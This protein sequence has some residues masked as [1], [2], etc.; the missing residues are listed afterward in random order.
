MDIKNKI[1]AKVDHDLRN[2]G[3]VADIA[4][5]QT[6]YALI[7]N[8]FTT[9]PEQ[10]VEVA[11][12][13]SKYRVFGLG[14]NQKREIRYT[15]PSFVLTKDYAADKYK[16]FIPEA[17]G[18][19]A[20]GEV[21]ST[22]ILGTPMDICTQTFRQFGKFETLSEANNFLS[23]LKT[24]FFRAL[25][26]IVKNTQHAPAKVYM[27]VPLQDFSKSWNDTELYSK[28]N[29]TQEEIDFIETNI[30]VME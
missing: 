8:V 25:V 4:S 29:L 27:Y 14:K 3:S 30:Q 23:Y 1:K 10:F 21:P 18:C 9:L 19:G 20:I 22:P 2:N 12:N 5:P 13:G 26:G 6:P 11:E 16:V 24:K 17:Y 7:S 15:S 28:Y